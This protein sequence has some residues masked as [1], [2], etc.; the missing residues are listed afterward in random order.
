[1][2][3]TA[4]S[5]TAAESEQFR[6]GAPVLGLL[7]WS[8][9]LAQ[10]G[11]SLGT[12]ALLWFVYDVSA[13]A[14]KMVALGVLQTLPPLFAGPARETAV[15]R[16]RLRLVGVMV[17]RASTLTAIPTLYAFDL[18]SLKRLY[19][20]VLLSSVLAM[21]GSP[22]T[23]ASVPT[24]AASPSQRRVPDSLVQSAP[25]LG[26]LFGPVFAGIGIAAIG[27]LTL[28]YIHAVLVVTAAV[29][30][31]G[32]APVR[33]KAAAEGRPG[34]RPRYAQELAEGLRSLLA[35]HRL[36]FALLAAV[37]FYSAAAASIPFM[38]PVLAQHR[39]GSPIAMGWVWSGLGAGSLLASTW[40]AAQSPH[41]RGIQSGWPALFIIA[42]GS[43]IC[44]LAMSATSL[45]ST[46]LLVIA[47]AAVWLF[48]PIAWSMVGQATPAALVRQTLTALSAWAM[49]SS[50]AGLVAFGFATDFVGP[51]AGIL[52]AGLLLLGAG[53]MMTISTVAM[54]GRKIPIRAHSSVNG[55]M[56]GTGPIVSVTTQR[57]A[58]GGLA[59]RAAEAEEERS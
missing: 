41:D 11:E 38:L 44:V 17:A 49:A 22:L 26:L 54:S 2:P 30:F 35:G 52:L 57:K 12:V 40:L 27:A 4:R 10:I 46:V 21:Y 18:L 24:S 28:L 9:L 48:T 32:L 6:L 45:S 55:L 58:A 51:N 20:L 8:R 43:A 56:S 14:L 16:S 3:A 13:S 31:P 19:L 33:R 39:L 7:L 59:D 25:S 42:G 5:V 29:V 37:A 1:M 47:G 50:L 23:A 34:T 36:L 53:A 15:F